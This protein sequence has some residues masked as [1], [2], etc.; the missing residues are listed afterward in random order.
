MLFLYLLATLFFVFGVKRLTSVKTCASGN[1]LSELG[2]A[3]AV[4]AT[5]I[6]LRDSVNWVTLLAGAVVGVRFA[7]NNPTPPPSTASA[8][9]R[10]R[11]WRWL[12]SSRSAVPSPEWLRLLASD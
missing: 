5:L 2:M 8:G 1:R 7:R 9:C 3:I 10:P 6:L 12:R 11:W 4:L